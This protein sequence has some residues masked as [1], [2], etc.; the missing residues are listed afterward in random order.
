MATSRVFNNLIGST[1][2]AKFPA[3]QGSELSVNCYVGK[4]GAQTYIESLPGLKNYMQLGGKCRGVFVSTI[5]LKS[6]ASPE[7]MFV[8]MGAKLWRIDA[9]GH[10]TVIGR[11]ANNGRRVCFAE[12]GGPRALLLLVDGSSMYY[13]DLLEGGSLRQIQLPERITGDGGTI[14]PTHVAVVAGSI[15]VNDSGSGYCYYSKPYPLNADTREM[16]DMRDGKVQYE[17]DG[18]TVKTVTVES[19]KHVFEDDYGVQQYFNGESSSDNVNGLYAVGPTLYMF[20]PKSVDVFQRGSGEFEDWIRTSYTS[21]NTFGLEAPDS[22]CS[23]GGSVFFVA[24]G[25]QYGKC[26]MKV[27]G[28]SFE[29]VSEDWL[30]QKLLTES[31]GSAYGFA[32][33]VGEHSWF[34]LQLDSLGE[35]W[36]MDLMDSG[37]HQRTSRVKSSGVEGQWRVGGIAYYREKFW[38]FTN[39]GMVCETCNDYWSEDYPDG[40]SLPMI[41]H[42]QTAVITDGLKPFTFEEMTIEANV[43]CFDNYK[44]AP[45]MLLEVSRDGG[46]TFG[47]VRQASFGRTGEYSHRVRFMNI[48]YNRLCVIRV[49]FSEPIDLVMTNCSIRAEATAEMI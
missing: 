38:A 32:Y 12:A 49:T 40:S 39:D 47:N 1:R 27:T 9:Y 18:V 46:M 41:R 37:W 8:V 24:S 11:V 5:G 48:G 44:L 19:D 42:R 14:T 16:F 7:D 43:G 36:C 23:I 28:T 29:R 10:K 31:T 45:K 4:N 33:A 13:Y 35:T 34:V 15:V 26:V 3:V 22:L 25:A 2:K 21:M 30:D 17:D 6:E 20:G